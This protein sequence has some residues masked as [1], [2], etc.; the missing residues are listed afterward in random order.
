MPRSSRNVKRGW[1]MKKGVFVAGLLLTVFTTTATAQSNWVEKFLNRYR[2]PILDPA[3]TLTPQVSDTPWRSM[4]D[5][6]RLPI[7]VTDIIRLMLGSNLD[8]TVNRFSPLATQYIIQ[9]LFRPFEPTLDISA[10]VR[11]STV[12]TSSQLVGAA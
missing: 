9:T 10:T 5:S 3:S 2:P 7:S 6:G 8:V 4:V 11:R 12:P 1:H